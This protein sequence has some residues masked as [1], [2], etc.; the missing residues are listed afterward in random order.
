[1]KERYKLFLQV[2]IGISLAAA[3]SAATI[4]QPEEI[5]NEAKN[6]PSPAP[7]DFAWPLEFEDSSKVQKEDIASSDL[8][9]IRRMN[10][11]IQKNVDE[12]IAKLEDV[13]RRST[14]DM[15]NP[16]NIYDQHMHYL[17]TEIAVL[18]AE[19]ASQAEISKYEARKKEL[20]EQCD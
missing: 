16:C 19:H 15:R 7:K 9:E 14:L 4:A 18:K 20:E 8:E 3:F 17:D 6:P 12:A 5:G 11:S 13:D 2:L 1:M 10:K